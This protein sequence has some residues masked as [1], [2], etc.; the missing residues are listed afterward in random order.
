MKTTVTK[1]CSDGRI[2]KIR[3]NTCA[4]NTKHEILVSVREDWHDG[5]PRYP[6][7]GRNDHQILRCAGCETFTYR[8]VA[9]NS[10]DF[11]T[12]ETGTLYYGK[13]IEFYP[14]RSSGKSG[15]RDVALLPQKLQKAY[16]ETLAAHNG[17]QLLLTAMGLRLI[18]ET[19]CKEHEAVG[20]LERKIDSLRSMGILTE[21]GAK[22]LHEVRE[23]GNEAAHE[24]TSADSETLGFAIDA[25]EHMLIGT[26]VLPAQ[27]RKALHE[28]SRPERPPFPGAVE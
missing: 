11:D 26:Y 20:N 1:D 6:V 12:D 8:S 3:C 23:I 27:A 5:H 14:P 25:V 19:V 9:T 2:E 28:R 13:T 17:G 24:T 22:I 18:I 21:A 16:S 7:E 15:I 10:E 4:H